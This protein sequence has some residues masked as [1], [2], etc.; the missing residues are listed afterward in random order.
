[1]GGADSRAL[2][3]VA[4]VF[5]PLGAFPGAQ[6]AD[7]YLLRFGLLVLIYTFLTLAT[8][9]FYG[10]VYVRVV[11]VSLGRGPRL[12]RLPTSEAWLPLLW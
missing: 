11:G 1:M 2:T 9:L 7:Q 10:L 4:G 6:T 12:Q 8:E 5:F 3:F